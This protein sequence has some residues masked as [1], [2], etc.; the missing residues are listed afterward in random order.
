MQWRFAPVKTTT[1][2]T[3]MPHTQI[4]DTRPVA[5]PFLM[6]SGSPDL[7]A[8][9]A[10]AL[11]ADA[12]ADDA[13]QFADEL[14]AAR[15][16]LPELSFLSDAALAT[17]ISSWSSDRM[18]M[19]WDSVDNKTDSFGLYALAQIAEELSWFGPILFF[20]NSSPHDQQFLYLCRA[21]LICV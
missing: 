11:E 15:L 20:H 19:S 14:V 3:T 17:L 8:R 10:A 9:L 16:N 5:L 18:C 12:D 7:R 4:I 21:H 1:S 2:R 13:V 6:I